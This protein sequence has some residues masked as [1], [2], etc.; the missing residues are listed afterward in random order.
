M[1]KTV[2]VLPDGTELTSGNGG[3]TAIAG[4]S[5]TENINEKQELEPG[6]VAAAV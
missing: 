2:F 3:I 5:L 1:E 4:V 6:T